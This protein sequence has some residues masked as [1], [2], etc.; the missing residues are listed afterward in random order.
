MEL[1]TCSCQRR[2]C[3]L[4]EM[5]AL[6]LENLRRLG[7]MPANSKSRRAANIFNKGARLLKLKCAVDASRLSESKCAVCSEA[8]P[9]SPA[10]SVIGQTGAEISSSPSK[11]AL[12]PTLGKATK[13]A[14]TTYMKF[15]WTEALD[16]ESYADSLHI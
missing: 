12:E 16:E 1:T 3:T 9:A 14:I 11:F 8:E 5:K 13:E 10:P 4:V 2:I 15:P 6:L 7:R